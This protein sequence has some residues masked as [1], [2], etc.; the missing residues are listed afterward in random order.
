MFNNYLTNTGIGKPIFNRYLAIF[1]QYLN[2]NQHLT[3]IKR[4][5]RNRSGPGEMLLLV[6]KH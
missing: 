6:C 5:L 3:N 4:S 2:T 1:N